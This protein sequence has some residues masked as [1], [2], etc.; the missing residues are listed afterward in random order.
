MLLTVPFKIS[1]PVSAESRITNS[2]KNPVVNSRVSQN[3]S[4]LEASGFFSGRSSGIF[5]DVPSKRENSGSLKFTFILT[6]FLFL[7][8]MIITFHKHHFYSILVYICIF[9]IVVMGYFDKFYIKFLLVNLA[10]SVGFDFIWLL[11]QASVLYILCSPIGIPILLLITLQSRHH[12]WDS[13]I[14][15]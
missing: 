10:L 15:S 13:C 3:Q 14:S 12:S 11:A 1:A 5:A 7:M 4:G 2:Y 8:E 9:A 6:V